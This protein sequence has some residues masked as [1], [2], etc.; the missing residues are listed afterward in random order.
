M[1]KKKYV[2]NDYK[3]ERVFLN[4]KCTN[5]AIQSVLRIYVKSVL[6]PCQ[7]IEGGD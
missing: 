3:I 7:I 6:Y 1:R 2:G 4:Q 5:D